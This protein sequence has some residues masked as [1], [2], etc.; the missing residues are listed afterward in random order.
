M[1]E[2]WMWSILGENC[3]AIDLVLIENNGT[4]HL[5]GKDLEN[6]PTSVITTVD[7]MSQFVSTIL[8]SNCKNVI[9]L[10]FYVATRTVDW[11]SQT[12]WFYA[13]IKSANDVQY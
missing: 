8:S 3:L 5:D 13:T 7:E 10:V 4:G 9:N 2:I 11:S 6:H 12:L 1:S